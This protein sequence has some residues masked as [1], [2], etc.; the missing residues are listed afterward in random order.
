MPTFTTP[1]FS[2]PSGPYRK[3]IAVTPDDDTVLAPTKGLY[4]AGTGNLVVEYVDGT[5]A[6]WTGI[7]NLTFLPICVVKVLAASNATDIK[8][9]Y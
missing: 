7:Q 4:V 8:A 5:Q 2:D 6:T 1:L 9:L 3:S